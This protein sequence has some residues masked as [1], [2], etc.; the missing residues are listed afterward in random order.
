MVEE[1]VRLFKGLLLLFGEGLWEFVTV[2]IAII[3]FVIVVFI[4][5]IIVIILIIQTIIFVVVINGFESIGLDLL[6]LGLDR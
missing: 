1:L 6:D 2:V 3:V 5:V 4:F